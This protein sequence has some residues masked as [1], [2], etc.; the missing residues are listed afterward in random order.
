MIKFIRA[1][2]I[3]VRGLEATRRYFFE[4]EDK[5]V[6]LNV[7]AQLSVT[8]DE[9][10]CDE[11]YLLVPVIELDIPTMTL[12]QITAVPANMVFLGRFLE[13][14]TSFRGIATAQLDFLVAMQIAGINGALND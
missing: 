8:T 11:V 3:N 9:E 6:S 4:I 10:G 14:V 2:S 5:V 7:Y 1:T 12:F 13:E